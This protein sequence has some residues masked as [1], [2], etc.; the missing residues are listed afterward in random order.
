MAHA[1]LKILDQPMWIFPGQT[2]RVAL[3]QPAGAGELRVEVPA[4]LELFD[5]WPK[6][7]L[8][9]FY[10]RARNPGDATLRFS[11]RGGELEMPLEVIPWSD[12]F[13]PRQWKDLR[14]PR[15]WPLDDPSGRELKTRRTLHSRRLPD[16]DTVRREVASWEAERNALRATVNWRFTATDARVKLQR[17]YPS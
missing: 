10:F 17:L 9:R 11:G 3:E 6:D 4:T 16:R 13:Q 1:D 12:V 2:F 7:T 14:L 15:I 8:Q 5:Q